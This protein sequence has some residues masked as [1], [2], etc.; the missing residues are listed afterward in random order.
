MIQLQAKVDQGAIIMQGILC[1]PQS[2]S[3]TGTSLSDCCVVSR[4]LVEGWVLLLCM[5]KQSVYSTASADG[6]IYVLD[7]C[8]YD[9]IDLKSQ[10]SFILASRSLRVNLEGGEILPK[11]HFTVA[12]KDSKLFQRFLNKRVP[13]L[14]K[15][16]ATK[17]HSGRLE[18]H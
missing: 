17:L 10:P 15:S 2:S 5:E 3:I 6:T 11:R 14:F 9:C 13:N 1:I 16:K 8:V 12:S 4:T 18:G 7:S